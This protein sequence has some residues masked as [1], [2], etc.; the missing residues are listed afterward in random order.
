MAILLRI[1]LAALLGAALAAQEP[2][3]QPP[4]RDLETAA[5]PVRIDA[6]HSDAEITRRLREILDGAKDL[7]DVEI[8]VRHGVADLQGSVGDETERRWISELVRNTEG[9]VAVRNQLA[10]RQGPWWD[11]SPAF[12]EL[13]GLWR[14]FVGSLPRLVGA[15]LLLALMV[16]LGRPVARWLTGPLERR[17]ESQLMQTVARKVL[18]IGF[19]LIALYLFLR[20]S[21][22]T[23]IALTVVGGTG[24]LGI[25]LGFAFRD[26]A[27]NFLASILISVQRPFRYGDTIEV[28][29][30]KGVVQRVTPRGTI[31]MD[32]EGNYIQ[33]ANAQVYKSPIKNFTANPRVRADFAFGIA[34]DSSI[35]HCQEVVMRVLGGHEAVL[36]EPAPMVLAEELASAT[37]NLRAYFWVDGSRHSRD[38]VRS[39]LIRM[40]LRA[41]E[42]EGIGL[43]DDAREVLFPDGVPV[44]M[45]RDEESGG[46]H[47]RRAV[48]PRSDAAT[49]RVGHDR[50]RQATAAEGGLENEAEDIQAQIRTS[51][52]PEEGADVMAS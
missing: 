52:Q 30:M 9:V 44:R 7:R 41:L 6:S 25:V 51:R 10:I 14:G 22:L 36:E 31:L 47:D 2:G 42:A 21:G 23:Q 33:L 17:F 16:L 26:I 46:E 39:A 34:Y 32:F 11:F 18:Q 13:L 24:V 48:P 1:V 38:K 12:G 37:I 15:F 50:Q 27:E 5:A 45:L 40:V 29:G 4:P 35:S 28:D 8:S 3:S 49:Q 19:W 20:V 43:P